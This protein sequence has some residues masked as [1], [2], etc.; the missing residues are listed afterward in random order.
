MQINVTGHHLEITSAI[1]NFVDEKFARIK[2][3][4]DQVINISVI[5]EVEKLDQ[6]AE[7]TINLGG[8]KT[9]F[10]NAKAADMY[11]AI[12]SLV[13]KLDRQ[14]LKHKDKLKSH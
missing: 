7:A 9:I 14:V 5:L 2:R 1:R 11:A 12:D 13:D 3:H 4:F 10:A 6:K 8:G